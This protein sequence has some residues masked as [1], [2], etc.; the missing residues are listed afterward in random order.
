VQ[1]DAAQL[2]FMLQEARKH[3]RGRS[4]YWMVISDTAWNQ[5]FES[6]ESAEDEVRAVFETAYGALGDKLNI[7]LVGLGVE[8][9][10]GFEDLLDT[11]IRLSHE[12]IEDI[13]KIAAKLGRFVA[14]NM[15]QRQRESFEHPY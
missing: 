5:C 15:L 6:S 11:D 1:S 14:R 9:E 12:D 7:S 13:E 4:I 2:T 3:A 10:T 8:E